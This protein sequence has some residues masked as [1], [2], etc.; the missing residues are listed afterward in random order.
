MREPESFGVTPDDRQE[1]VK[2]INGIYLNDAGNYPEGDIISITTVFDPVAWAVIKSY[3]QDR[4]KVIIIDAK[5]VTMQDMRV[6]V[7][8]YE[9][10]RK[11]NFW[12]V[13]LELWGV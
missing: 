2:C 1:I 8:K 4:T 7:K 11:H 5:D 10:V 12:N 6:V 3:W 13:N 9:Y